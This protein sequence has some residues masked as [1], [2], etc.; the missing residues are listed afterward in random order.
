MTARRPAFVIAVWLAAST[1]AVAQGSAPPYAPGVLDQ[2]P[3]TTEGP[4]TPPSPQ[5]L[6]ARR[7]MRQACAG[8][9]KSFCADVEAGRG[10]IMR[11][12]RGHAAQLSPACASAG[13]AMREAR[14]AAEG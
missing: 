6:A 7:A 8:D 9:I 14:H 3:A 12:L 4:R 11:C 5:M 1:G 13:Q 10:G 2:P